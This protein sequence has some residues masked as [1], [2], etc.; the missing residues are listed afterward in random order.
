[1]SEYKFENT[2]EF[3]IVLINPEK[4]EHLNWMSSDYTKQIIDLP[5]YKII[6]SNSDNFFYNIRELLNIEN[7]E[8][9]P[10]EV[11]NEIIAEEPYYVYELLYI[12]KLENNDEEY[13]NGV[14]SLLNTTTDKKIYGPA[15][16]L[17]THLKPLSNNMI[18]VNNTLNDIKLILDN[19]L[20]TTIVIYDDGWKEIKVVGDITTWA[21]N[22]FDGIYVKKE[23]PFLL[24]NINIWYEVL[25]GTKNNIKICGNLV[26]K[27]IYKCLIFT[28]KN[29]E[30][31]GNI[32]LSEVE[33][34][35][36]I[37]LH[38]DD[39]YH[40]KEEWITEEKDEFGRNIIKNKYRVLDSAYEFIKNI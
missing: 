22:F 1:M 14:A 20:N 26:N 16:L 32:Y 29:E 19:R 7:I 35:I 17:K 4:I 12:K 27:P 40:P 33:K 37:S 39:P 23:I 21:D 8:N 36:Q 10:F 18:F 24:H 11:I 6:S 15:L 30:F 31:R 25:E 13:F 34:I 38:L 9:K 2:T 5:I 3:D 28:M